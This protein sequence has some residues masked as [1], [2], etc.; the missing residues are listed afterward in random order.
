M[1]ERDPTSMDEEACDTFLGTGGT[2]V[3]AFSSAD[4]AP[5]HAVPVSYG[6]DT[7]ERAFYFRLAVG[8]ES[9][10]GDLPGRAV[11]FV[12]YDQRD[13]DWHSV[14]A[15]GRLESTTDA[16]VSTETLAGLERVHIPMVDV[17]GQPAKDV[18]FEFYRLVPDE[19]TGRTESQTPV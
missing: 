17:F 18:T 15:A 7:T 4:E 1:S 3:M 19:L 13:G 11:T 10:K 2:G 6:Y 8:A 12:V 9:A 14:V 16:S 5:P